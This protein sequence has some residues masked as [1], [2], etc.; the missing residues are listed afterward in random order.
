MNPPAVATA[1]RV[2]ATAVERGLVLDKPIGVIVYGTQLSPAEL[3]WLIAGMDAGIRVTD[4]ATAGPVGEDKEIAGYLLGR[5]Y[6]V[7]VRKNRL[8]ELHDILRAPAVPTP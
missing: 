2:I 7:V 3:R 1:L 8:A 5:V 6:R 4:L